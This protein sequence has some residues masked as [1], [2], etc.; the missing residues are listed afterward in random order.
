MRDDKPVAQL[1]SDGRLI[2]FDH[3]LRTSGTNAEP[4]GFNTISVWTRDG[5]LVRHYFESFNGT[6][7]QYIYDRNND[8]FPDSRKVQEEPSTV[9]RRETIR[10][11]FVPAEQMKL[12]AK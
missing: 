2:T 8:F 9:M 6:T 1:G 5:K 12:D 7:Q 10:Y 3:L 11:E 4:A